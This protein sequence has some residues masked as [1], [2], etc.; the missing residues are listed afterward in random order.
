VSFQET[1]VLVLTNVKDHRYFVLDLNVTVGAD[2]FPFLK[3]EQGRVGVLSRPLSLAI[4]YAQKETL[5]RVIQEGA[6]PEL[7]A[8]VHYRSVDPNFLSTLLQETPWLQCFY[9]R[10]RQPETLLYLGSFTLLDTFPQLPKRNILQMLQKAMQ[11]YLEMGLC[12]EAVSLPALVYDTSASKRGAVPV[13]IA[14]GHPTLPPSRRTRKTRIPDLVLDA[15]S[16]TVGDSRTGDESRVHAGDEAK[17]VSDVFGYNY[18]ES[19][20]IELESIHIERVPL[21]NKNVF[22]NPEPLTTWKKKGLNSEGRPISSYWDARIAS[23]EN[24]IRLLQ[25][26]TAGVY[27]LWMGVVD[28]DREYLRQFVQKSAQ[29]SISQSAS[30]SFGTP[31]LGSPVE[32]I[33]KLGET[34]HIQVFESS[35]SEQFFAV[36]GGDFAQSLATKDTKQ[37]V[38][39]PQAKKLPDTTSQVVSEDTTR[40]KD[41][42]SALKSQ[43]L[44]SEQLKLQLLAQLQTKG[45]EQQEIRRDLTKQVQEAQ[46][47]AEIHKSKVQS[48]ESLIASIKEATPTKNSAPGG[49]PSLREFFNWL[50]IHISVGRTLA[51]GHDGSYDIV[52]RATE[53]KLV[54]MVQMDFKQL[55]TTKSISLD[56]PVS[57]LP[58]LFLP[59][60]CYYSYQTDPALVEVLRMLG[61]TLSLS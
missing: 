50:G 1:G 7:L 51:V 43:L 5:H 45:Q 9:K 6:H 3:D 4:G 54:R 18:L 25:S 44:A 47:I 57:D 55:K 27:I 56:G 29:S 24:R 36:A 19:I 15:P 37:V 33:T 60:R 53:D 17:K 46:G 38:L 11:E 49:T 34:Y 28:K 31:Q 61:R 21:E 52:I 20:R 8:D 13:E 12:P 23:E 59:Y 16:S 32:L 58:G 40:L 26:T 42:V 14:Q 41:E 48:L 39:V 30:A 35:S 10:M 2:T 22:E